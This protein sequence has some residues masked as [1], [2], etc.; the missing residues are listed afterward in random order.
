MQTPREEELLAINGA[1]DNALRR[2]NDRVQELEAENAELKRQLKELKPASII[3]ENAKE[4]VSSATIV[5]TPFT[6]IRGFTAAGLAEARAA[7]ETSLSELEVKVADMPC[8]LCD[9]NCLRCKTSLLRVRVL[10]PRLA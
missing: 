6:P 3:L 2:Q 1:L 4:A 8:V 5:T 7:E 9:S 10:K